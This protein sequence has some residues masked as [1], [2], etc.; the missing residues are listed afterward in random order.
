MS[1]AACASNKIQSSSTAQP[2]L[3]GEMEYAGKKVVVTGAGGFV[4][5]HLVEELVNAGARVTA[6]VHYNA[7]SDIGNLAHIP[8]A[9]RDATEIVFGDVRDPFLVQR[10]VK[11]QDVVFHLAALIGIPYSYHAPQSYVQTN[12]DGTLNVVQASLEAGVGRVVHTSTS[13]VYGTAQ[14]VPIDE[15]HPL[16]P[17]S[18][19]AASKVGADSMAQSYF[20]SFGLPVATI[21]PF[22]TFGPRQSARAVIP[23]ILSQLVSKQKSLR[24]GSLS[25]IRDFTFVKDLVRAF[26][27]IGEEEKAVG[28]V[29]NVG[30]GKGVTIQEIVDC[31]CEIT[32]AHPQI[33]VDDD[34]I[35]PEQSEVERLVCDNSR[36][37]A[38]L[39]WKPQHSLEH[40]LQATLE[41]IAANAAIYQP[42][43][44]AI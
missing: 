17:Q 18:P 31:C 35:R 4:G 42:R 2:R 9:A 41:F 36:A 29:T 43:R 8:T 26:L 3:E 7:R 34:R 13:E 24:I 38:I 16:H 11:S 32:G 44:Y 6:L 15:K 30:T 22:I 40:G 23:T 14:Y 20:L 28:T 33:E 27:L 12:I 10:V 21:R 39:N 37:A 19:Y 25:P 5:S 1:Q